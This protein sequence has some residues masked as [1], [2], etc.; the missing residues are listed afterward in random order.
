MFRWLRQLVGGRRVTHV[1]VIRAKYDAAQTTPDN[2]KHWANFRVAVAD[3]KEA[4]F[5]AP[6]GVAWDEQG[7]VFVMDWNASGRISRL[8][9]V[10]G[11]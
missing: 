8:D 2:R 10:L 1:R 9:R 7:N 3:W 4:V 5:T 11:Q 6:H